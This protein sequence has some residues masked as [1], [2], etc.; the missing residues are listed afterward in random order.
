[1]RMLF[2]APMNLSERGRR[3]R[4]SAPARLAAF[5]FAYFGY[6][7]VQA[8]YFS[9]YLA[10]EAFSATQIASI[11]A[12]A[13]L[14]RIFAPALWGWVSD[15]TGSRR[16][17]VALSCGLTAAAYG[18]LFFASG[19]AQTMLLVALV[20][21]F[22]AASLPI[23]DALT[24]SALG[25]RTDRYGP[26]RLWGSVG[27]IL[28]VLVT[29]MLLDAMPVDRLLWIIFALTCASVLFALQLPSPPALAA[30]SLRGGLWDVLRRPDVAA[31][32]AAC[33]CMTVAHGA[34]Y[35]FY[36]LY[37]VGH[38]YSKTVIG[39]LWTLGVIAEIFVFVAMPA[40]VRRYSLRALLLASFAAAGVRFVAIGWGVDSLVVLAAAQLLHGATFGAYHAASTA[41]VH[42]LFAGSLQVRGQALYTSLSYGVGGVTG[43]LLAGATWESLGAPLTFGI[44]ALFGLA[45]G[46]FI[47]WRVRG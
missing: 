21:V 20:G 4:I 24:F 16:G 38:G 31:F 29:G 36:S 40:L 33:F 18:S 5:Y 27:F 45:G 22:S 26:V 41:M 12:M 7:G 23:V 8:P 32:F 3:V 14:A 13:P 43:M 15:A 19:F 28:A 11:L 10:G 35:A 30:T 37:L 44:S 2:S 42:R 9:L 17:V 46:A 6:I 1:M 47:A 34:L 39:A 25:P